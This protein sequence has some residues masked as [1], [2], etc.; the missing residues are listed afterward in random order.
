MNMTKEQR[1]ELRQIKSRLRAVA[2]EHALVTSRCRRELRRETR[3]YH[4]EE[5]KLARALSAATKAAARELRGAEAQ[6]DKSSRALLNRQAV[7]EG[8]LAS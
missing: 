6:A 4:R 5:K 7:L 8:R 3:H 2:G 1:A